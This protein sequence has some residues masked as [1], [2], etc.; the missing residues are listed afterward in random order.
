MK[1]RTFPLS[2]FLLAAFML[3]NSAVYGSEQTLPDYLAEAFAHNDSIQMAEARLQAAQQRIRQNGVLPD[4]RLGVEYYLESIETRTGPQESA[5]SLSQTVPW[6]GKLSL[7]KKI[8]QQDAAISGMQLAAVKLTVAS[9][10]K[11]IS[12]EYNFNLENQKI[13][14]EN[15]EL[16][17]YLE[18]VASTRYAGGGLEYGAL[19]KIQVEM[20]K[21]EENLR[22]V[23]DRV[24]SIRTTLN[25]LLGADADT[26][27][28][29]TGIPEILLTMADDRLLETARENNPAILEAAQEIVKAQLGVDMANKDFYPDFTFSVKTILTGQAEFGSPPDSGRDPVIA[30][31]SLNIPLFRDRRHGA[32]EEK[33]ATLRAMRSNLSQHMRTLE[34]NIEQSLYKYRNGIRSRDLYRETLLPA[35]RQQ[36]EVGLEAFQNGRISAPELIDVEKNL[37]QFTLAE[38]QALADLAIEVARLEEL[39]GVTLADWKNDSSQTRRTQ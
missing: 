32:M 31:V 18:S 19:L 28:P 8:S 5:I 13:I 26:A 2:L 15:L 4:P 23:R 21:A 9:K 11:Q 25:N 37:L 27:R 14:E 29:Q 38:I 3:P 33:Q 6:P 10:V 35:V 39:A 1:F 24:T 36:I 30:G 22:S 17:K 20:A 16:L 7:A 12:V 34:T